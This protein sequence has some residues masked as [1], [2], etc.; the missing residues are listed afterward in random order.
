MVGDCDWIQTSCARGHYPCRGEVGRRI[1]SMEWDLFMF[2]LGFAV[3]GFAVLGGVVLAR[4]RRE[5]LR[6]GDRFLSSLG[7]VGAQRFLE[8]AQD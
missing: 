5:S 8:V 2:F 3:G 4:V 7:S 1:V 6:E